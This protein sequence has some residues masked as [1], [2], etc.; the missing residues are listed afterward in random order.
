MDVLVARE[1]GLMSALKA[2]RDATRDEAAELV[3]RQGFGTSDMLLL[4][5][6]RRRSAMVVDY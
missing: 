2:E 3:R 6:E 4:D 5:F 1:R